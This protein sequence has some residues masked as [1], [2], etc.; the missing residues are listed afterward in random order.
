MALTDNLVA[1]YKFDENTG[2]SV[3]D[4]SGNVGA[5]TLTN[6]PTWTTGIINSG[7]NF[8]S[9]Q[10]VQGPSDAALQITGDISISFWVYK[11]EF[12]NYGY[13]INKS[14]GDYTSEYAVRID[15]TT[16]TI[17]FFRGNG[18]N[19]EDVIASTSN[20][21][22]NAWAHIVATSASLAAKIYLNGT[23]VSSAH[24]LTVTPTTSTTYYAFGAKNKPA[25]TYYLDGKMDELGIWSRALTSTEVTSLYNGGAGLAYP[26]SAGATGTASRSTLLG[27]GK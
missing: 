12:T 8:A 4:A 5:G 24:T 25:T 21:P 6:S 20:C 9:N 22:L 27:V 1:Y 17:K 18:V 26:F 15:N 19:N 2:T 14:A 10:Y 11:T 13:P 7:L 16:G 3:A 23:L